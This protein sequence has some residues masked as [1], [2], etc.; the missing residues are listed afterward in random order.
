MLYD[1]LNKEAMKKLFSPTLLTTGKK[2]R[3]FTL[4]ELLVSITIIAILA[5]LGTA[6]YTEASKSARNAKRKSDMEMVRQ[7]LVLRK[8]Q[9]G[10]YGNDGLFSQIVTNM[11]NYY[12][13]PAPADPL[14]SGHPQYSGNI[15]NTGTTFCACAAMEGGNGNSSNAACNWT[16]GGPFYCV[17]N[18]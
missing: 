6:V 13:G 12:S 5:A 4:V 3:G 15:A 8:S 11:A 18:P 7:A 1:A 9:T 2:L 10:N 16:T 17:E 14:T